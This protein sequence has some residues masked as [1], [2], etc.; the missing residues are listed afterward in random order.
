MFKIQLFC[1]AQTLRCLCNSNIKL[2][3][4]YRWRNSPLKF[5]SH[6]FPSHLRWQITNYSTNKN[7]ESKEL[8]VQNKRNKIH[9]MKNLLAMDYFLTI[10]WICSITSVGSAKGKCIVYFITL[11]QQSIG[12]VIYRCKYICSIIFRW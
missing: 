12:F 4:L 11:K 3:R 9:T 2:H 8:W 1:A 7:M 6:F 5:F 10:L